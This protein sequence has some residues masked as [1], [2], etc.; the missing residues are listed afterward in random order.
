MITGQKRVPVHERIRFL[1][2]NGKDVLLIDLSNGSARV[3]EEVMQKV[4]DIVATH[5]PGSAL[6]L[7]DLTGAAF[8]ENAVMS[9]KEAAV[10]NKPYIRKSALVGT[11]S[12]PKHVYEGMKS[13]ARREW[14]VFQSRTEALV[15]LG[16]D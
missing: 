14:G 16:A 15:W 13:F 5:A 9:L 1:N 10:F 7:T 2:R 6:V 3:V 4:P 8:D 12:L 11:E